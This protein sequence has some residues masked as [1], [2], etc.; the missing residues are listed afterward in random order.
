M[1]PFVINRNSWHYKLNAGF[2][3]DSAWRM[4]RWERRHSNF[5]SYWRATIIRVAALIILASLF[6]GLLFVLGANLYLHPLEGLIFV[7]ALVVSLG[8]IGGVILFLGWL[9]KRKENQETSDKPE[10]LFVQKY[11]THKQKICP[12]VEFK[13]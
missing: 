6:L 11:R 7:A 9:E 10:S 5:C 4:D 12:V 13:E 8:L 1:K 2:L 3:N